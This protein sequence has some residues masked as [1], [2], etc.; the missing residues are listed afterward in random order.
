MLILYAG[1]SFEAKNRI[2]FSLTRPFGSARCAGTPLNEVVA[3]AKKIGKGLS[4]QSIAR[5]DPGVVTASFGVVE[6]GVRE[7]DLSSLLG[8]ADDLLYQAKT[9]AVI[10]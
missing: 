8:Q 7:K 1:A 3:R 9:Q 10:K 6:W 5:L 4:G 2:H